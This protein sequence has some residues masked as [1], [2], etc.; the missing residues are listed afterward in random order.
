[1]PLGCLE[2]GT[3][4]K[5]LKNQRG[6]QTKSFLWPALSAPPPSIFQKS[7]VEQILLRKNKWC[8]WKNTSS[9]GCYKTKANVFWTA[10]L[11]S[12][13]TASLL[14]MHSLSLL[15]IYI[16]STLPLFLPSKNLFKQ[17]VQWAKHLLIQTLLATVPKLQS[18][19][20]SVMP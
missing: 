12:F 9:Y 14:S 15:H 13:S 4:K 5:D 18:S 7:T 6:M 8:H 1:M 19:L 2:N 3:R 17:P 11:K 10:T 20:C 16:S